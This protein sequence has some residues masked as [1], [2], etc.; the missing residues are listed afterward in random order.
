MAASPA[1][2]A[3]VIGPPKFMTD[4]IVALRNA[5]GTQAL[6][7]QSYLV[8]SELTKVSGANARGVGIA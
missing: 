2:A 5:G 8:Q 6:F 3:L 7:A 4:A 1:R